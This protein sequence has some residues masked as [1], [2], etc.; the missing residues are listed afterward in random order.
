M[1]VRV[2]LYITIYI[3]YSFVIATS[4]CQGTVTIL[5]YVTDFQMLY[6]TS[7]NR[8][9]YYIVIHAH[10]ASTSTNSFLPPL[11]LNKRI[12][13]KPFYQEIYEATNCGAR[14]INLWYL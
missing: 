11:G 5:V 8:I 6:Y 13:T 14:H 1:L 10:N 3:C 7:T 2:C 9:A 12:L 4:V